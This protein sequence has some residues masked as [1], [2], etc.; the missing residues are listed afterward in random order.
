M[1]QDR[2]RLLGSNSG[3]GHGYERVTTMGEGSDRLGWRATLV[4]ASLG[5]VGSLVGGGIVYWT[6][7]KQIDADRGQDIRADRVRFYADF[8]GRARELMDLADR[9]DDGSLPREAE[10]F[11]R[12]A[13]DI[14]QGEVIIR[15][16]GSP[17]AGDAASRVASAFDRYLSSLPEPGEQ[18]QLQK[19]TEEAIADFVAAARTDVAH[20]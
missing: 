6:A 3:R 15:L 12:T 13:L 10:A 19:A 4:A 7:D 14:K 8:L 17:D 20:R 5:L 16:V 9:V 2:L 11:T 1:W 18:T